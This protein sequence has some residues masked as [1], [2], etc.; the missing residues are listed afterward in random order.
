VAGLLLLVYGV[1]LF[2]PPGP[3]V[4]G[5][6]EPPDAWLLARIF[7]GVPP[8]WVGIRLAALAAAALLL[9]RASAGALRRWPRSAS[10]LARPAAA[11]GLRSAA[12]AIAIL[13]ACAAP[14]AGSLGPLGQAGYLVLLFVPAVLLAVP[15]RPAVRMHRGVWPTAIVILAWIAARLVTDPNSPRVADV[16]DGWRGWIDIVRFSLEKKNMLTDLF[17]PALPGVGGVLLFFHGMPWLQ[18]DVVSLTFRWTQL[19]QIFWAAACG[20]GV[21]LLARVLVA[22]GVSAIAA[23]VFLFSPYVRF[24]TIFPGPFLVG[25]LYATAIAFAAVL[26]CRRRSES[27]LAALGAAC[28]IGLTFPGV[29]PIVACFAAW[30]VWHLRHEVRSLWVG[31]AAG[32]ASF[33]AA[34]APALSQVLRPGEIGQHFRWDGLVSIVDASILGQLPLRY[35]PPA[36]E[37]VS[38]RPLDMIP[39]AL[40]SPFAHPRIGVRLW[41]DTIFDP[42]GAAF[43]AIGLAACLW[44]AFRSETAR[45]LLG[46]FA[47][48]LAPG[49]ISPIDVVD[50]TH[51]VVIPVPVALLA[52]AGFAVVR[53]Q[54]GWRRGSLTTVGAAA[55]I[56]VGGS[57]LFDLVHPR[58]LSASAPGIMFQALAPEHAARVV[59]LTYGPRFVR[60]TKTLF[61]GPVT[62]YAGEQ[63]VG[64]FEYGGEFPAEAFAAE[65]K[66]LLFWSPAFDADYEVQDAVC[67]QWPNA[68][69][70]EIW[71]EARLGRTYG[72]RIGGTPWSPRDV[73]GRWRSWPCA[74]DTASQ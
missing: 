8:L 46:F 71:D 52:A 62:A 64:Y 70:Y 41:G 22:P 72:A 61:T 68:T 66:D 26:A 6:V 36:W 53:R 59:W 47:V 58:I 35:L 57:V 42:L 18:A 50:I 10:L 29:V 49:F 45:V 5:A 74:A 25:P 51:A 32:L 21:A 9:S 67:H 28:G 15:M 7:P 17:D 60:P 34:V 44:L 4:L 56:S 65:G 23:A 1:P 3:A 27:A 55:A 12:L 63:P 43:V 40:L 48:A 73:D 11:P 20:V 19:C 13:H 24:V 16:V 33:T 37:G 54:I 39:A 31:F 14:W 69:L 2:F 38:P 30:T